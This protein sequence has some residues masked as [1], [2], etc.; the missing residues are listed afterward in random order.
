LDIAILSIPTALTFNTMACITVAAA[1]LP[2]VPLDFAGN[3]DRIL[4]SI[5]IAKEKGATIRTG[6]EVCF[7][8]LLFHRVGAN[9]LKLEIPGYGCLDHH[10]GMSMS[11]HF[12]W[13][14]PLIT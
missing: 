12:F 11:S 10:L 1:T 7:E 4:Q 8:S 2:S 5:K 9:V 3:R 14:Y 13:P 6:P